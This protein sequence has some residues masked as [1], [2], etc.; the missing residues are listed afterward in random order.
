MPTP[1]QTRHSMKRIYFAYNLLNKA[2]NNAHNL[3]V[4][5]YDEYKDSPCAALSECRDCFDRT[6][7]KARA[8]AFADEIKENIKY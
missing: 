7:E 8:K 4:I 1:K 6:T 5:K 3:D 2:L